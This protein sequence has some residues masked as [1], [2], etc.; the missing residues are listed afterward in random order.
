M[1][2]KG[3]DPLPWT[4][5][6]LRETLH[7]EWQN[8][9]RT[10]IRW[11]VASVPCLL[12]NRGGHVNNQSI[13]EWM[14]RVTVVCMWNLYLKIN[15][16]K[17]NGISFTL[18]ILGYE[19]WPSTLFDIYKCTL[20]NNRAPLLCYFKLCASFYRHQ[21]IQIV[22]TVWKPQ[23]CVKIGDRWIPLTKIQ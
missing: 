7:N 17:C 4:A 16:Q 2:K 5:T 19:R 10:S 21:Y 6:K 12:E 11:L 15:L 13:D 23:I 8:V 22:V 14:F 20:K 18:S 3:M 1:W 9:T